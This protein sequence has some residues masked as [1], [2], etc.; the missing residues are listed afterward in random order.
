MEY[1]NLG[2]TALRVSRLCLGTMN[3]GPFTDEAD[4]HAIMDAARDAGLNFFD[5]ANVYGRHLGPG[6]TERI[7]GDWFAKGDGRRED[8]VLA[9]KVYGPVGEGPNGRG[10]SARHIVAECEASLR[11]LRTDR[12][13]LYQMHHVDR[14]APWAEVW[15]AMDML[16]AQGKVLYVGSSNFAG[17]H[18]AAAQEAADRRNSLGLVSEQ[19]IYNLLVRHAELDVLPAAEHYGLGVIPWSPLHSGA[20]GGALRKLADGTA[21]RSAAPPADGLVRDHRERLTEWEAF[22]DELGLPPAHVAMAWLL[23][24]P[25]VT[26]PIVGPRTMTHLT[27]AFACLDITLDEATLARLD[28]IFPPIGKGGPSPEAW[29]W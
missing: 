8:T 26:A 4:S 28:E 5:T 18:I 9:T 10:L 11:R 27:D 1:T 20:L 15:Q 3:F 17:W 23:S 13:D 2:R 21:E 6:A 12:I 7:I 16:V 22:C 24:R 19:C 29:A 14:S 25:A